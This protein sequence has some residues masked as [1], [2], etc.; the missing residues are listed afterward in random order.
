MAIR[1]QDTRMTPNNRSYKRAVGVF[2]N[3][4]DVEHIIRRLKDD[5]YDMNRVSLLAR[6]VDNIEGADEVRDETHGNEAK[7]GA[8]IGASTGTILGGVTGFLIGVGVLAIPGV[9]PVLAAG[10][11]IGALGSTLAGAGIGAATGG[12]VGALIGLGIPEEKAKVY[13]N[14]IKAGDYLMMVSGNDDEVRRAE[15]IMRDRNVEEFEIFEAPENTRPESNT[16]VR[17]EVEV[18]R[19]EISANQRPVREGNV[20]KTYDLDHDNDP[21]VI[22]VDERNQN[23]NPRR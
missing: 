7:E 10:A 12:I 23:R 14:R 21:E 2:K 5:N 9:G 13:E 6:N 20:T 8:G 3:Q 18:D 16:Y 11:E 4:S 1:E 19:R 15:S 17:E 22:V